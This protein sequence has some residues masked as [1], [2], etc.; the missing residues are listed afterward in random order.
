MHAIAIDMPPSELQAAG[1]Q[2]VT[3]LFTDPAGWLS[4]SS[5]V[6]EQVQ[7]QD[8]KALQQLV[9]ADAAAWSAAA[10]VSSNGSCCL[11]VA[12]L[13]TL[14]LRH[15]LMQVCSLSAEKACKVAMQHAWML[16]LLLVC[17]SL[18]EGCIGSDGQRLQWACRLPHHMIAQ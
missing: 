8:L 10:G 5:A 16:V 3:D 4:C 12:G 7:W 18:L 9:Q 6:S 11:V 2:S 13:S 1:V 15:P 14:L 17:S